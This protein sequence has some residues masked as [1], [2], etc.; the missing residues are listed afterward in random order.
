LTADDKRADRSMRPALLAGVRFALANASVSGS[1][2][3]HVFVAPIRL[4]T[5]LLSAPYGYESANW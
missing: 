2:H 4:P 1:G 5:P 3:Q